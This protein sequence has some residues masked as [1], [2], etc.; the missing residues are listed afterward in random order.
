MSFLKRIRRHLEVLGTRIGLWF[1]PR[2]PRRGVLALARG[3]AV[4]VYPLV[5]RLRRIGLANLN[6][7]F[8][9]GLA[10]KEK[11]RILRRSFTT[12]ATVVCDI[13]WFTRTPKERLARYVRFPPGLV[14]SVGRGPEVYVTGHLGNWEAL[15]QAVANAGLPLHS[16]AAPL[17]NPRVDR[18]FVPSRE[19]S[20]QHILPREGALRGLLSALRRGACVAVLLDQNTKPS[21]SGLFVPFFGVPAPVSTGPA[22]LALRTGSQIVFGFCLPQPDGTY[23]V[24]SPGRITPAEIRALREGGDEAPDRLTAIIAA[25]LEEAVRDHPEA[26]LWTYQ[27]W[28][29]IAPGCP[30]ADYPYYARPLRQAEEAKAR[31]YRPVTASSPP[32]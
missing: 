14:E 15:G 18:L 2:L 13:F 9:D 21:E 12:F 3:A 25:R 31:V 5:P 32:E 11:R 17:A 4:V 27:R 26:W 7:A 22:S 1:I 16:V 10:E 28:K 20:G 8:G 6:L 29:Y 19:I 24:H 23:T 30:A